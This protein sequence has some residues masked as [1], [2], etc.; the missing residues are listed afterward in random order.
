MQNGSRIHWPFVS[1]FFKILIIAQG[2]CEEN[3]QDNFQDDIQVDIQNNI[4]VVKRNFKDS[5]SYYDLL[6]NVMY[7]PIKEPL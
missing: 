6:F 5:Q 1:A 7:L 4:Q 2:R 3:V